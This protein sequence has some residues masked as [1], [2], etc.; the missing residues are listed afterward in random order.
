M[1]IQFYGADCV[2]IT[3]KQTRLIIDDNLKSLGQ[4]VITKSSDVGLYT[5]SM[6]DDIASKSIARINI[7]NPGEYEVGKISIY[8]IDARSHIDESKDRKGIIYKIIA[9]NLNVIVTGHIFPELDEKQLER[10]GVVDVLIVPVGGH[11]YTLDAQGAVKI[12]KQIEP[13]VIIPTHFNDTTLN[14]PIPQDT[15]EDAL[16]NMGMQAQETVQ[17][18]KIKSGEISE[19]RQ[20]IVLEKS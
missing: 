9:G 5:S 2:A 13:K 15:L 17:K 3:Y 12:I 10:I 11:G 16:N 7:A 1:E 18:L 14:F 8:G 20:L 19:L 4:K 6:T